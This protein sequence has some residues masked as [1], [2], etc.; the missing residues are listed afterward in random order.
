M[1]N[2]D[3]TSICTPI[4]VLDDS[5]LESTENIIFTLTPTLED[6]AVVNFTAQQATVQILED[7]LDG[8]YV[9]G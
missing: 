2:Y 1:F 5:L 6:I 8:T 3:V 4:Y 9:Y 7:E